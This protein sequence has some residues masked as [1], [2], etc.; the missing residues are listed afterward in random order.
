MR[1]KVALFIATAVLCSAAAQSQ[2]ADEIIAK[3]IAVRGGLEKAK[4]VQ[5]RRITGHITMPDGNNALLVSEWKRPARMRMD[6]TIGEMT[7]S[8]AADGDKGW[9]FLPFMGEKAPQPISGQEL[10]N[11]QEDSDMDGPFLDYKAKGN[12]V[13]L[14][15]KAD[16]HGKPAYDLKIALADGNTHH[17]FVDPESFLV[18]GVRKPTENGAEVEGIISDYRPVEGLKFPFSNEVRRVGTD[19]VQ[20]YTVEKIE[21]NVTIDDSRFQ[22]PSAP[23]QQAPAPPQQ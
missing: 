16:F 17:Y 10:K 8:R 15:G 3:V 19:T 9:H 23:P 22:M 18:I 14:L 2:T 20:K 12:K 4:A 6:F 21:L 7:A 13:D 5:T 1:Y 11:L